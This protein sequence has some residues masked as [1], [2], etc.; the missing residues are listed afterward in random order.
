MEKELEHLRNMQMAERD[1]KTKAETYSRERKLAGAPNK[2]AELEMKKRFL[3]EDWGKLIS[4]T[5]T[6]AE[7]KRLDIR[8]E[9]W[10]I[11]QQITEE[12]K[13][14]RRPGKGADSAKQPPPKT[15]RQRAQIR[16][17]QPPKNMVTSD[18]GSNR[19][20]LSQRSTARM[21]AKRAGNLE[22]GKRFARRF[23]RTAEDR[24]GKRFVPAVNGKTKALRAGNLEN[25]KSLPGG[26]SARTT[27]C[28]LQ[29]GRPVR[30]PPQRKTVAHE[31]RLGHRKPSPRINLKLRAIMAAYAH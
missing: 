9:M 20:D 14:R 11:D 8:Q 31:K 15:R 28:G 13:S 22:T 17:K 21:K 29:P 24:T 30:L 1:L 6:E 27:L 7:S 26:F 10:R 25:W 12:R 16:Q 18:R 2:I 23:G 19:P 5:S 4:N 3:A